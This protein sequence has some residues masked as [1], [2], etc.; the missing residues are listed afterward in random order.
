MEYNYY[1]YEK[2][3]ANL[4]INSMPKWFKEISFEGNEN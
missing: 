2:P 1:V 4:K 3:E